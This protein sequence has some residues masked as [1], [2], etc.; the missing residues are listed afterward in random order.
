M[1]KVAIISLEAT[2]AST[3]QWKGA[4]QKALTAIA[5]GEKLLW[6][7]DF[8]PFSGLG[9]PLS[10]SAQFLNLGLALDHFQEQ[11]W[12]EFRS[13]SLGVSLYRISTDFLKGFLWDEEQE[14]NLHLW[15]Q[16][17]FETIHQLNDELGF[18]LESFDKVTRH[19]LA[20]N[21]QGELLLHLFARDVSADYLIELSERAPDEMQPYLIFDEGLE[22]LVLEMVLHNRERYGRMELFL[23]KPKLKWNTAKSLEKGICLPPVNQVKP[24][25]LLSFEALLKNS[26]QQSIKLIPEEVLMT[27]W[28]GLNELFYSPKALSLQGKRKLQGFLAA[29][30]VAIP[31]GE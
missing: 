25:L 17:H 1:N 16:E 11:V 6:F 5:A 10:N 3:L 31:L 26:L 4:R 2:P 18:F 30:G 9:K 27:A 23:A 13:F 12:K 7:L 24:S 14:K 22:D 8:G 19:H 21:R 15:L 29:G 20:S 28:N